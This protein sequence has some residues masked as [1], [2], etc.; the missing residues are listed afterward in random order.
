MAF[1]ILFISLSNFAVSFIPKFA[2]PANQKPAGL[3]PSIRIKPLVRTD[4]PNIHELVKY[5]QEVANDPNDSIYVLASSLIFNDDIL[6]YACQLPENQQ[7]NV[8][9]KILTTNHIDKREGFPQQ[10]FNASYIVIADPIQYHVPADGQ[11]V[12]G[13]PARLIEQNQ[14]IGESYRLLPRQFM[15]DNGVR[16]TI[17]KKI[18]TPKTSE[19]KQL[20]ELFQSFYPDDRVK[21][22][23]VTN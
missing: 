4:L 9:D 11:R 2:V 14:G 19:L 6:R 3:F 23:I 16:A 7:F 20:Q 12:I 15:L 13:I 21:F 8:C 10:L 18:S 17:Y 22:N 5:L 1:V